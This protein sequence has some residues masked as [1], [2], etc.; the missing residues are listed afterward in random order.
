MD[1]ELEDFLDEYSKIICALINAFKDYIY[2]LRSFINSI[3]IIIC[4]ICGISTI[5]MIC[6]SLHSN[7]ILIIDFCVIIISIML[8]LYY[9]YKYIKNSSMV[10]TK[11]GELAISYIYMRNNMT[12]DEKINFIEQ[13]AKIYKQHFI[14][15]MR[16]E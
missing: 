13:C 14:C 4:S 2:S 6:K 10:R 3:I 16:G 1:K 15:I 7:I 12:N 11:S 8:L 9:K 5:I